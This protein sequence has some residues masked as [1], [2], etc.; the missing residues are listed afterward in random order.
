M[1]DYNV[2][3][4]SVLRGYDQ[5]QVDH[6]MNELAQAAASAWQE[7]AERTRQINEL[8][9]ANARLKSEAESN[10][11]RPWSSR[12]HRWRPRPPPTRAL[13]NA[14]AQS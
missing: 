5:T 13:A 10:A 14:S 8:T 2:S 4:R 12:R 3:F 11:Q 1:A 7:A 9:A 6:H